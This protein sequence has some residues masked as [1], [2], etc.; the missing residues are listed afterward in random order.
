[1]DTL[2][3]SGGIGENIPQIRSRICENL[4][5]LG[6]EL[7]EKRNQHHEAI[8]SADRGKVSVRVIATNEELM[9]ARQV[10]QVL[11]QSSKQS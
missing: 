9:I 4:G 8:I 5:F 11:N 2:I 10:S 3:F 1:M 6:I 7:N